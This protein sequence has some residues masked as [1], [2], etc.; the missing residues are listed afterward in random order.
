MFLL[1]LFLRKK[2]EPNKVLNRE[3]I[4]QNRVNRVRF[5]FYFLIHIVS[6]IAKSGKMEQ[7]KSEKVE[8]KDDLIK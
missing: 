2:F 3:K 6:E 5:V 4:N 1:R 8:Y 7:L